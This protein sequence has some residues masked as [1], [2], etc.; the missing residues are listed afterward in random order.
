MTP[1]LAQGAA[2]AIE[3]AALLAA[4]LY[5]ATD[6]PAALAAYEAARKPR[7]ARLAEAS[8]RTGDYYHFGST[9]AA[10]RNAALAIAGPRLIFGQSDWI[11]RWQPTPRVAA[12]A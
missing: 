8:K 5:G 12:P 2:M 7:V 4:S 3:D 10:V 9:M 11:Y 1:F 6:I